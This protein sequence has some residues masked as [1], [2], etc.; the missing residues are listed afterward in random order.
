ML[1]AS[2]PIDLIIWK[3]QQKRDSLTAIMFISFLIYILF[4]VCSLLAGLPLIIASEKRGTATASSKRA[5]NIKKRKIWAIIIFHFVSAVLVLFLFDSLFFSCFNDGPFC[6]AAHGK[7][8]WKKKNRNHKLLR[9][10]RTME[11]V[12]RKSIHCVVSFIA[13]EK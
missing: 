5:H 4:F 8:D 2:T 11:W 10:W 12:V 9:R 7:F 3:R 1:R 13:G 6:E